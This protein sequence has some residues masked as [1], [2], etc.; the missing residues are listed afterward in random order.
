MPNCRRAAEYLAEAFI[1]CEQLADISEPPATKTD[2]EI[3]AVKVQSIREEL[4]LMF[5]ELGTK[6]FDG[7]EHDISNLVNQTI[8]RPP[9]ATSPYYLRSYAED[10]QKSILA[11]GLLD[12]IDCQCASA[13]K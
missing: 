11:V 13:R 5:K 4:E 8:G 9:H 2:Q 1:H 12:I 7:F 10:L 6:P 3:L